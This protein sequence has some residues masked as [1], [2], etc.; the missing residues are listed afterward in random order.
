MAVDRDG[1]RALCHQLADDLRD[2]IAAGTWAP[3]DKL[4]SAAALAK[5]Y[6]CHIETARSAVRVLAHEGLVVTAPR[7]G[8]T[9]AGDEPR[10]VVYLSG[11]VRVTARMPSDPE[12]RELGLAHG[13]PFLEVEHPGSTSGAEPWTERHP[14]STT[15]LELS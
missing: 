1:E 2:Q 10:S 13:V 7:A 14:A 3:G 5:Q 9:V 6:G 12:R 15:V 4:P 8:T 11:P